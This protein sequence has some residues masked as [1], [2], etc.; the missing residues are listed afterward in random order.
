MTVVL[1][2][3]VGLSAVGIV[4]SL[5]VSLAGARVGG[6][7]LLVLAAWTL[8]VSFFALPAIAVLFFSPPRISLRQRSALVASASWF[9]RTVW[10]GAVFALS[11]VIGSVAGVVAAEANESAHAAG[12][13]LARAIEATASL[14]LWPAI[15]MVVAVGYVVVG[16]RWVVELGEIV[17]EEHGN[18]ARMLLERRWAGP[19][20]RSLGATGLLNLVIEF[21][22]GGLCRFALVLTLATV[23]FSVIGAVI[24]WA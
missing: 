20:P 12:D 4:T 2:G 22:I 17:R 7:P 11:I 9:G 19:L 3:L 16:T 21:G 5:V 14:V 23:A 15:Q 13:G 8:S 24:S 10:A 18:V 6:W 1:D